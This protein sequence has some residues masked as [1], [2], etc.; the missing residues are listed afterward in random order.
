M[1]STR[2][3]PSIDEETCSSVFAVEIEEVESIFSGMVGGVLIAV[4][5]RLLNR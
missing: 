3:H 4:P 5:V 1:P 2:V